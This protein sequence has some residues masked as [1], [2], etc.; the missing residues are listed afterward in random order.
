MWS[1]EVRRCAE[2]IKR[3]DEDENVNQLKEN[4]HMYTG[5]YKVMEL[6][7]VPRRRPS[8]PYFSPLQQAVQNPIANSSISQSHPLRSYLGTLYLDVVQLRE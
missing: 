4:I 2:D 6:A 3:I 5:R 7:I 8:L 1:I